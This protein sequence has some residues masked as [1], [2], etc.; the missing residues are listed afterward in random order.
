M[1]P[2]IQG[3][4]IPTPAADLLPTNEIF[5]NVWALTPSV[6]EPVAVFMAVGLVF[7]VISRTVRLGKK[8]S[9]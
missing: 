7:L 4:Q 9:K 5:T 2:F 8:A 3:I 6:M 1:F